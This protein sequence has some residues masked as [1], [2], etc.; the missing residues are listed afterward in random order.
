MKVNPISIVAYQLY[1]AMYKVTYTKNSTTGTVEV[2][3]QKFPLYNKR[4]ELVYD[5]GHK[6]DVQA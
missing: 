2:E 1:D 3:E 6:I 5:K 4:A